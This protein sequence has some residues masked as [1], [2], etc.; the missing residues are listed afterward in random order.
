M[1]QEHTVR[2]PAPASFT[3]DED[4]D[5]LRNTFMGMYAQR[6][7]HADPRGKLELV[8]LR[9]VL[10]GLVEKPLLEGF[11]PKATRPSTPTTVRQ[12]YFDETGWIDCPVY[13]RDSLRAA[14]EFIGPAIIVETGSTTVVSPGD[15]VKIDDY[16][17]III[18]VASRHVAIKSKS[19]KAGVAAQ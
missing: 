12:T 19:E 3:T 2:T 8:T 5:S 16:G 14:E 11:R 9:V 17:N 4:K 7:G 13:Q 6:Y 15:K 18:D 1:G 10:D